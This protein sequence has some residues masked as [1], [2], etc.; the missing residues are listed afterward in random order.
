MLRVDHNGQ[1]SR[2]IFLFYIRTESIIALKRSNSEAPGTKATAEEVNNIL[3]CYPTLLEP[4]VLRISPA[5]LIPAAL[6]LTQ[7]CAT[8]TL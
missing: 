5:L 4:Y 7:S 6:R 1:A 3:V 8:L 2:I